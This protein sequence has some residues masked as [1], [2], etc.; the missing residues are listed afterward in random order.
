MPSGS[1]AAGRPPGDVPTRERLIAAARD[2]FWLEGYEATGIARI[3][4]RA[5]ANPGSLY[6]FF[7]TK[8]E[9]LEAVLDDFEERI[10]SALLRPAWEGVEDPLER[11]FALLEAYR[12]AL[13]ATD[14]T[15]GCPI[16]GI[17]LE[18]R[19]PPENVRRK[20][21]ANFDA[22][23]AAVLACLEEA[24]PERLPPDTDLEAL[25]TTVLTVMEGG[26]MQARTYRSI[27]AFDAGVAVLREHFE[28][29]QGRG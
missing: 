13:L 9:L 22:W 7:T 18:L 20:I 6:H 4:E 28:M 19:A 5:N 21:A 25:A 10:E 8:E 15:Y 2:L 27:E 11:V 23:R 12:R 16:G 1:V 17:A 26:V 3:C 14:L 24:T 29:L